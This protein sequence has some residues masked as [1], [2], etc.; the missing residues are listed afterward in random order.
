MMAETHKAGGVTLWLVT[1][2]LL[3]V[4]LHLA[5]LVA[6][7][8]VPIARW[9][10]LWPDW[11]HDRATMVYRYGRRRLELRWSRRN[12]PRIAT[13]HT[14]GKT[15]QRFARWLKH[16][17]GGH[18]GGT[19]SFLAG[20]PLCALVAGVPALVVGLALTV[21]TGL[22][23]SLAMILIGTVAFAGMVGAASH[24][25]LDGLTCNCRYCD[26]DPK[27]LPRSEVRHVDRYGDPQPGCQMLW[28]VVKR[29]FGIPMMAVESE[30]EKQRM[31][32]LLRVSQFG[33]A[34][35]LLAVWAI[36]LWPGLA[37]GLAG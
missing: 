26:P 11:D 7:V 4:P 20:V 3:P 13:V 8:G 32:P 1:C 31:L 19:H 33:A 18:R 27:R 5:P 21:F 28:P 14:P 37:A 22:D 16:R 15:A 36:R 34:S 24:S 9:S 35:L 30:T 29:R 12:G 10:A 2:S 23:I 6:L 17:F 25:L